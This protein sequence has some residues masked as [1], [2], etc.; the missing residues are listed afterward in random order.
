[1]TSRAER[2][3]IA[4]S[5]SFP[6]PAFALVSLLHGVRP[7]YDPPC[8]KLRGSLQ[9][10]RMPSASRGTVDLLLEDVQD[11]AKQLVLQLSA[12]ADRLKAVQRTYALGQT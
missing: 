9:G 10:F 1:M 8:Q 5:T 7:R 4:Q 2:C 12:L 11:G 6:R 3:L